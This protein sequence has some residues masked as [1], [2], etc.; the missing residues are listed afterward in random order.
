M[1]PSLITQLHCTPESANLS[2]YWDELA[3]ASL[4]AFG[5]SDYSTCALLNDVVDDTRE[6]VESLKLPLTQGFQWACH[7]GPLCDDIL[8]GIKFKILKVTNEDQSQ[9]PPTMRKS[10]FNSILSASPRFVEPLL[11]MDIICPQE[12]FGSVSKLLNK[13]RGNVLTSY[14]IACT[15]LF[16]MKCQIPALDSFGCEVDIRM[17]T[18]GQ[19]MV[20][21]QFGHYQILESDPLLNLFEPITIEHLQPSPV[22]L[23]ATD[24][25]LKTR[26]RK[27]LGDEIVVDDSLKM[28][29]N[30]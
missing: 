5:P 14:P 20:Y 22:Q 6:V 9:L 18:Q 23:L 7:S 1:E 19:A 3:C 15:P 30:I 24:Y 28:L 2:N 21:S 16:C 11:Y 27:G 8:Y 25:M 29:F 4:W 12:C 10:L 13:R 26:R 17:V